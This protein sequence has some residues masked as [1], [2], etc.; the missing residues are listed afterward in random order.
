[1][2]TDEQIKKLALY[3][4]YDVRQYIQEHQKEYEEFIKHEI[5]IDQ[6][7]SESQIQKGVGLN[8]NNS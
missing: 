7:S 3:I 4:V 1:M 6:D 5:T 2:I 8:E